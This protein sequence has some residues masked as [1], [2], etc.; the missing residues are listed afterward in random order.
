M[1]NSQFFV[2]KKLK[3]KENSDN[4]S[5]FYGTQIS[6]IFFNFKINFNFFLKKSL[7][8]A[9]AKRLVI[10]KS[11]VTFGPCS[12]ALQPLLTL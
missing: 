7:L 3:L 2:L 4:G 5:Y 1:V 10:I 12:L 11:K 6:I 9:R 8:Q